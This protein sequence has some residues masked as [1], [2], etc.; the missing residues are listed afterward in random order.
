MKKL[1][2]IILVAVMALSILP[3]AASADDTWS[4][5]LVDGVLTV[6]GTGV[7]TTE[8][9]T[10]ESYPWHEQRGEITEIVVS[11]GITE[12]GP[13][14]FSHCTALTKIT[15]GKDCVK[16]AQDTI[17]YCGAL[18][19]IVFNG[20]VESIGQGIVYSTGNFTKVTITGQTKDEFL[21]VATVKPYNTNFE[22][23]TITWTVAGEA[24]E[25]EGPT[26][27]TISPY[28]PDT[29][30]G[31]EN[32]SDQT[33]L[34][35]CTTSNVDEAYTWKLTIKN[36]ATGET[37][38][39]S[40]KCSSGYDTWLRR[41]EV[42]LG[43]GENQFIPENGASYTISAEI[44]N[45][46]GELV[47]TAEEASGFVCGLDPIVPETPVD[48]DE[49]TEDPV[50]PPQAGDATVMIA[51]LAVVALFGAAVVTKKVFVK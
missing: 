20:T 19:E 38:T 2:A 21:A 49:P 48:P 36:D 41:F 29:L 18:D 26:S 27:V 42:C 46:A 24:V 8:E 13:R 30:K 5:T 16:F 37:K 33:Q 45:D 43:E 35:I 44:Y 28:D 4:Y 39:I 12:L 15:F 25:P 50:D 7:V 10:E 51:V 34:L 32:W 40:L 9:K 11:D 6:T 3:F 31:F 23:D 17:S 1:L 22:N 14:I 47:M